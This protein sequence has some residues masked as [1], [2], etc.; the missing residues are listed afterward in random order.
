MSKNIEI[1]YHFWNPTQPL[2]PAAND[3]S[4]YDLVQKLIKDDQVVTLLLELDD[5]Q[6][7]YKSLPK[8]VTAL[9]IHGRFVRRTALNE[10]G[11]GVSSIIV[12]LTFLINGGDAHPTY[13]GVLFEA[14]PVTKWI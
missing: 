6:Q 7:I 13:D 5:N 1:L 4:R 8:K 9:I 12:Q 3:K 10:K 11:T 2:Q 14:N